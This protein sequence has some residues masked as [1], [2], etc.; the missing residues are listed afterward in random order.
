MKK[1]I[2]EKIVYIISHFLRFNINV[3]DNNNT[4]D[5]VIY[6]RVSVIRFGDGEF[7][8]IRGQNIP[9]QTYNRLL[10]TRMKKM[11]LEGSSNDLLVCL[12]DVFRKMNRYTPEC[13]NFYYKSFFFKNRNLLKR[14]SPK[15][16]Y[17]STFISRP[18]IDI[19]DKKNIGTYFEKMKKV[20]RGKDLLIVEGKYTRSGEGN[21]LFKNARTIKRII[22]PSS[23]AYEKKD[24]IEDAIKKY[25]SR[26]VILL[27]LGPT[28]KIIIFDLKKIKKLENQMIDLGHVDTEYEWYKMGALK[29]TKIPH[30]HTAEFNNSD[31]KVSLLNDTKYNNEVLFRLD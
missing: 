5:E 18:Y 10:A 7:D 17:G 11:I 29:R 22:A 21:D 4:L 16:K 8:I 20:W 3:M 13:R 6:K 31:D 9:Y 23:N 19:K 28:S 15:K 26:R 30:K 24:I 2:K 27:M 25:A 12:P 1:I 14:I